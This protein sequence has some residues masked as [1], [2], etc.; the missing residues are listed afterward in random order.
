MIKIMKKIIIPFLL[1]ALLSGCAT[2]KFQK[3][4]PPYDKGYLVSYDGKPIADYTAGADGSLPDLGLAKER[5]RRRRAKVEYYYKK[6]GQIESRLSQYLWDPLAFSG[7][8]FLGIIRWPAI[9]ICDYKYNHNPKYK[10]R[11]DALDEKKD[12][13]EQ[14]RI[15]NLKNR[16]QDYIKQD[17]NKEHPVTEASVAAAKAVSSP[18]IVPQQQEQ[19]KQEAPASQQPADKIALETAAQKPVAKKEP[20]KV[21][22]GQEQLQPPVAV[23]FARP[24]KGYSPLKVNFYANKCRSKNGRIVSYSWDFGDGD[25]SKSKNP[26]NTYWSA[27]YGS[28]KFIATLTIKDEKGMIAD[29][30]TVIEVISQ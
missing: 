5:F 12:A 17:L 13:L 27:T 3:G 19:L 10:E 7:D 2:Y 30:S 23:I 6:M 25:S 9:A 4:A 15:D 29:A 14:A 16:L 24:D 1:S 18:A 20:V 22:A 8:F 26:V 28:R 21:P 11:I